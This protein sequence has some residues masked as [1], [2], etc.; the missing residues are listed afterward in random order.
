LKAGG[1]LTVTWD[2]DDTGAAKNFREKAKQLNDRKLFEC[3][4]N[5]MKFW[6]FP[7]APKGETAT[8]NYPFVFA[9]KP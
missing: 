3:V 5:E 8:V 6:K 2:I 4:T 7:S 1:K 9:S